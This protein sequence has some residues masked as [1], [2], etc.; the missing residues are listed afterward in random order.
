M[1]F[2]LIIFLTLLGLAPATAQETT[3]ES[4][5]ESPANR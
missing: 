3:T 1:R 2:T 5:L 4:P